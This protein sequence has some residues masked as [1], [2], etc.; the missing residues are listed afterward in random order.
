MKEAL[1][2]IGVVMFFLNLALKVYFR[3][4][5]NGQEIWKIFQTSWSSLLLKL[6]TNL[7]ETYQFVDLIRLHLYIMMAM[8]YKS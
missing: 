2:L 6:L 1:H 7:S 5:F 3:Y 8:N 4:F